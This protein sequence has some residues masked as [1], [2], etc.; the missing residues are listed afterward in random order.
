MLESEWVLE[1]ECGCV[2][3][4]RVKS[5]YVRVLVWVLES[6]CVYMC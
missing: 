1:S 3:W 5:D 2:V 6:K 4:V